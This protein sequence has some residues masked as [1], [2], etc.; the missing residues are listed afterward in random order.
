MVKTQGERL[1]SGAVKTAIISAILESTD[2]VSEPEIRKY[3]KNKLDVQDQGTINKHIKQ[4]KDLGCVVASKTVE[5]TRSNFWNIKTLVNLK[6]IRKNFSLIYLN[7][8]EKSIMIIFNERGYSLNKIEN[9]D[10]YIKLFLSASLFDAFLYYDINDLTKKSTKIY[11]R[12]DGYIKEKNLKYHI[13]NFFKMYGNGNPEFEFRPNYSIYS[14]GISKETFFKVYQENYPETTDEMIK[15]L[16]KAY[17]EFK[18]IVTELENKRSHMLLEHFI[19]H[20]TFTDNESPDEYGFFKD[21]KE[22]SGKA[23]EI[24][25]KEGYPEIKRWLELLHLEEL[26]VY[27]E[28]IQKYKQP[29]MF[30][31]SENSEIIYG[32]LKDF[33]KEQI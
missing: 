19:N 27:S 2:P 4:L 12:G 17:K 3:L 6:E 21:L 32:M 20:D 29:S 26:K 7:P 11:L 24:W 9:L 14:R 23:D 5:R 30:Y 1:K 33:Y 8:Y 22:C 13:D 15:E 25:R 31:I 10:F 28:I 18:E 16:E